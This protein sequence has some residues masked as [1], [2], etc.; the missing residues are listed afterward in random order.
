[1]KKLL[2]IL[3]VG[4]LAL[5]TFSCVK[6]DLVTFD[7]TQATAPVIGS[8]ELGEKALTVTYTPGAFNTGFNQKMP[9]N[10][11]LILASVDGKAVDKAVNGAVKDGEV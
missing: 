3:S 1:M 5:V 7:E 11:S 4:L 6:E 8:Y 9:V 10:H 2:S